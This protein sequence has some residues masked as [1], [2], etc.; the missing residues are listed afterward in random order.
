MNI[1]QSLRIAMDLHQRGRLSEAEGEYRRVLGVQPGQPDALHLLGVLVSQQGRHGEGLELIDR[2]IGIKP[3]I[4]GFHG[5]RGKILGALGRIDESIAEHRKAAALEPRSYQLHYSLGAALQDAGRPEEAIAAYLNALKLNPNDGMT[6]NNLGLALNS[7]GRGDEAMVA[8]EQARRLLPN[9]ANV[10][11]NLA[12]L[13][14]ERAAHDEAMASFDRALALEPP[15]AMRVSS[16]IASM[17]YHPRYDGAAL[18]AAA[19]RWDEQFSPPPGPSIGRHGNPD[20]PGARD[21]FCKVIPPPLVLRGRAG[22]GVERRL[23]DE[24]PHPDPP[25]EYQGRER[26]SLQDVSHAGATGSMRRLRIGYVSPDLRHHA[27]GRCMLSLLPFHDREAFEIHCYASVAREDEMS[28][29]LRASAARWRNI[30]RLDDAQA[31][32]VIR[33]DGIDIL[34]DLAVHTEGNR[35]GV[36]ARKPAP[37]QITYL[38]TCSTT[39]LSAM[40]YRLSDPYV[41]PPENELSDYSERTIRLPRTHLCYEPLEPTPEVSPP[42]AASAG[43]VTFGC[44]NNFMK[45]SVD[46]LE[47][48]VRILRSAPGSR[49]ILHA[50]PGKAREDVRGRFDRAGISPNRLEFVSR[51]D[52]PRTYGRIDVALDPFPYNGA[53]TTCDALWMGV[54]VVTLSGRTAVGRLGRC[55]LSN[56]GL[57]ELVAAT[58]EEYESIA[59]DLASDL[60]RLSKL[61][62]ELRPRMAASPLMNP[63]RLAADI[64]S[65]FGRA[66][67]DSGRLRLHNG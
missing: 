4:A 42:P 24:N 39:G 22:V 38:G 60:G 35:L 63:R 3:G 16:R 27:V 41:D 30:H 48:W 23:A 17:Q 37:V 44:L 13:W 20:A 36:F 46:A 5:N 67:R 15:T 12:K 52:W 11:T 8:L 61:R 43:N 6:F 7:C 62:A 65:A 45:C 54:P 32:E 49:L 58:P 34:V 59:L 53:I 9:S 19:R 55:I 57:P 2:A 26:K 64:E 56:A 21:A 28:A 33:A 10:H 40:D 29:K 47:T 25:P 66:W 50:P 31:V 14:M 18:L 51:D 1:E